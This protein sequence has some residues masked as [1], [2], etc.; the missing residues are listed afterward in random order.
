MQRYNAGSPLE[1]Q[2]CRIIDQQ[3]QHTTATRASA[4]GIGGIISEAIVCAHNWRLNRKKKQ[5]FTQ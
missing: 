4:D 3:Q 5:F 2:Q 1:M